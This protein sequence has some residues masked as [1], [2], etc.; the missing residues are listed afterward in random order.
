MGAYK[1][2]KLVNGMFPQEVDVA[3]DTCI[4]PGLV[5]A[6]P[7]TTGAMTVNMANGI[8]IFTITPSGACTLNG[9]GGVIGTRMSF[10]I[11]TSGVSSFNITFG[12]NFKSVGVLATG[13]TTGKIFAVSFLCTNGVQWVETGR[14]AAQ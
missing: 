12:T 4:M 5:A 7:A 1:V 2:V 13:T 14:T 10:V 8:S 9:S 3:N 6:C 11:T